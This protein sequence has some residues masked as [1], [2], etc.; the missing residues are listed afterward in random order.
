MDNT[1]VSIAMPNLTKYEDNMF[2]Y[3]NGKKITI[4]GD[5]LIKD[6]YLTY[7]VNDTVNLILYYNAFVEVVENC[8]IQMEIR[9]D[10]E[11]I[12]FSPKFTMEVGFRNIAFTFPLMNTS[13]GVAHSLDIKY[14]I[15]PNEDGLTLGLIYIEKEHEHVIVRG[16]NIS[17]SL[18]QE[19]PHAEVE[20]IYKFEEYTF[21][22]YDGNAL[23]N[24]EVIINKPNIVISSEIKN[25]DRAENLEENLKTKD[26]VDCIKNF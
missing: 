8:T 26:Q 18:D 25:F 22:K 16:Q 12:L 21:K 10:N 7:G 9:I 13:G 1:K 2:Y 5:K 3:S 19:P 11:L 23:S 6:A 17:A 24:V 15:V 20:E 4:K 14:K